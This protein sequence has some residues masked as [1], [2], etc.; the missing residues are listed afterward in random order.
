MLLLVLANGCSRLTNPWKKGDKVGQPEKNP[1]RISYV[2]D[3][4][5]PWNMHLV[6]IEGFGLVVGL[7]GTG[8]PQPPGLDREVMLRELQKQ[9]VDR[10]N[11]LLDSRD[12]AVVRLQGILPP[13]VQQ[14]DR[15]DVKVTVPTGSEV[16]SLRG[17]Y[18][19]RT[20][21][22]EQI[23][24]GTIREG[25]HLGDVEGPVM[26]SPSI[27]TQSNP[28]ELTYGKILGGGVARKDRP[29]YLLM[30]EEHISEFNTKRIAD[31]INKRF[32]TKRGG[33]TEGVATAKTDK[34]VELRVH[35]TY[36]DNMTR[37]MEVLLSVVCYETTEQ[38]GKRI[39]ELQEAVLDHKT[40]QDSAL[41]LEALGKSGIEPLLAGLKSSDLEIRFYCAESL[42]YL[43]VVQ[44]VKP[45]A[46]IAKMEPA[47]RVRALGALSS[48]QSDLEAEA[49]LREMLN[50]NSVETRYGAFRALWQRNPYDLAIRGET[51]GS[52]ESASHFN[53]HV[54]NTK[55]APM[56]HVTYGKR[57]ELVLFGS[58]IH[59][60]PQFFL[61]AGNSIVVK[62]TNGQEEVKVSRLN[63][64][65]S[66][67]VTTRLD[68]IIK[69]VVDLGGTY[70]DVVQMLLEAQ[71]QKALPCRVEIDK[72]PQGGRVYSRFEEEEETV[73]EKKK[74]FWS[75]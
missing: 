56:I 49:A 2:R 62:C 9:S 73:A 19:L 75:R 50:E 37:Y 36:K 21:L 61:D 15:F 74:S 12:T 51:L 24:T 65:Q 63:S 34:L 46:E 33:K 23:F 11:E 41:K 43:N 6:A 13:G 30:K 68:E 64:L 5:T 54:L 47:F 25:T 71:A 52:S 16:T 10:P 29:L 55:G 58:D 45:L 35:P 22:Q 28:M 72:L 32:F 53:Y 44:A 40:A 59:L 42:A 67:I 38:R 26:L 3:Y 69:A 57:P 48:M 70:P 7:R 66:R 14:G 18:L 60:M 8:A 20:T 31:Q 39:K 4:A 17:G 1:Y 27:G